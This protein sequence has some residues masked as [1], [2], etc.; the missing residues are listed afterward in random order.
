MRQLLYNVFKLYIKNHFICGESK[1]STLSQ[2]SKYQ[3]Q[4]FQRILLFLSILWTMISVSENCPI[5]A[6]KRNFSH[7]KNPNTQSWKHSDDTVWLKSNMRYR[8][9]KKLL[10]SELSHNCHT[11]QSWT[12]ELEQS[13]E[14]EQNWTR[15]ENFD[16]SFL[17]IGPTSTQFWQFPDIP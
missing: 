9:Y 1:L 12:N 7:K 16:N 15:T 8:V 3:V 6:K 4:D 17:A 13:K 10:T 14:I 2:S 11:W 5:F